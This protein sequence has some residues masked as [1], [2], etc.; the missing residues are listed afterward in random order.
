MGVQRYPDPPNYKWGGGP[1]DYEP[2]FLRP[3]ILY[4]IICTILQDIK[5]IQGVIL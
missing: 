4:P 5:G 2:P 3:Y 1:E